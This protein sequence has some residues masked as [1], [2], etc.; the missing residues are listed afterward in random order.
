MVDNHKEPRYCIVKEI[1]DNDVLFDSW[2]NWSDKVYEPISLNKNSI[3]ILET[4]NPLVMENK[5]I[6]IYKN[7]YK[8][9]KCD[10]K[11]YFNSLTLQENSILTCDFA[12]NTGIKNKGGRIDI[13]VANNIILNENSTLHAN[14]MGYDHGTYGI[15]TQGESY[16]GI[17]TTDKRNNVGGGGGGRRSNTRNWDPG[18][19]AGGGGFGTK[20]QNGC[21]VPMGMV[22]GDEIWGIGGNTYGD[23]QLKQLYL[24]SGG[25][26]FYGGRGGGI[27]NIQCNGSIIMKKGSIIS[28]NGGDS[29]G[30]SK[31]FGGGGS[32]GSI[33]INASNIVLYNNECI[34]AKGGLGGN[35]DSD[36]KTYKAGGDGGYGRIVV[37]GKLCG[38]KIV[39]P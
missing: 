17:G 35:R 14:N 22:A 16:K 25:G 11:Y 18:A 29:Y 3:K 36:N 4:I 9:L 34:K 8:L 10:T 39:L 21:E 31:R 6:V 20:G 19:G 32:G 15:N 38:T 26:S 24:G 12:W 2:M 37:T 23:S 7:E 28:C 27:I 5:D 13:T 1:T 30:Y 33:K